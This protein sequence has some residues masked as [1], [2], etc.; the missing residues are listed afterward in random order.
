[1]HFKLE[2]ADIN[3]LSRHDSDDSTALDI[4]LQAKKRF[5]PR[6]KRNHDYFITKAEVFE[7]EELLL[8]KGA[9]T[10]MQLRN[11]SLQC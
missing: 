6:N 7:I 3:I 9:K 1:L 11:G 8:T 2:R 4:L 10:A 5:I